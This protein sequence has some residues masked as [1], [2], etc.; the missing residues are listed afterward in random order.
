MRL[1]LLRS[2]E[3]PILL[4]KAESELDVLDKLR[5][6]FTDVGYRKC[7]ENPTFKVQEITDP[8]QLLDV[9]PE[10]CSICKDTSF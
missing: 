8:N 10:Q 5:V 7:V 6:G 4:F 9:L 2:D 1:W 3:M